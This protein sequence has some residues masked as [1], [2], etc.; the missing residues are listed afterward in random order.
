MTPKDV[1]NKLMHHKPKRIQ[2]TSQM[3]IGQLTAGDTIV[4]D[5]GDTALWVQAAAEAATPS[6][7]VFCVVPVRTNT[8]YWHKYII[9]NKNAVVH[10]VEGRLVFPGHRQQSPAA[11]AVVHF[12][13][14]LE[15]SNTAQSRLVSCR[16]RTVMF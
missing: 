7:P 12:K 6:A 10:F 14:P 1:L 13:A 8:R 11:S 9:N 5:K 4:I 2:Y 3:N 15:A 16:P